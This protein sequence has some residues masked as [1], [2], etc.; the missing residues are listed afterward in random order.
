MDKTCKVC[1][2]SFSTSDRRRKYCSLKCYHIK[3]SRTPNKGAF[4]P[5]QVP[6]NKGV[7]GL[8]L[9]PSTEFQKGQIGRNWVPVG[10][11]TIRTHKKDKRRAWVKVA[12]PNVWK[13]RAIIVWESHHGPLP[14]GKLVHH[15]DRDS[16]NDTK[17]NLQ[18]MTR[19]EHL[20]EHRSEFRKRRTKKF[21][22]DKALAS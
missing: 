22:P 12:E 7:K 6:W 1:R 5:K 4:R 16:L 2:K 10:T 11:V 13:L 21:A 18:A 17:A 14:K 3:A 15:R 8:R 19:A 9:S 20:A